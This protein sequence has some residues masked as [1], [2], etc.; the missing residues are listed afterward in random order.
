VLTDGL[1][2]LLAGA[3]KAWDPELVGLLARIVR[4]APG[5]ARAAAA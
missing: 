5:G 4:P 3:G 1:A 2:R